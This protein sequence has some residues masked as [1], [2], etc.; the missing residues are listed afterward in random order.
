MVNG[1]VQQPEKG[2]V[3]RN[4]DLLQT[5]VWITLLGNLSRQAEVLTESEKKL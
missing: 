5:I 3:F 1:K 4:S 2:L